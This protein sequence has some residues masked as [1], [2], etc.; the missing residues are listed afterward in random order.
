M[1]LAAIGAGDAMFAAILDPA[2]RMAAMHGAPAETNLL[3]QQDAFV[4]TSPADV[5]RADAAL[6]LVEPAT[7]GESGAHDVRH[8][9]SRVDC[10]LLEPRVPEG[11]NAAPLDRR[12]ALPRG[13]NF[14]RNLDRRVER[15][16]D[17]NIEERLE[18][19]VVGPVLVDQ[20]GAV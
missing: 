11:D 19:D 8:L 14:A 12:H 13:A 7:L 18:K 17:I 2:H 1:V 20:R 9:T 4:A 6:P 3:R 10:Q 5:R 16:A 15:L